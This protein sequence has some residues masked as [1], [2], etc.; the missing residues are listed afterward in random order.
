M[1]EYVSRHVQLTCWYRPRE[2]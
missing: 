2:L 1:C